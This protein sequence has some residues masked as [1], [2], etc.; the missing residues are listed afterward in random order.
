MQY[1]CFKT[2]TAKKKNPQKSTLNKISVLRHTL[3]N[4]LATFYL[5]FSFYTKLKELSQIV[6]FELMQ[7]GQIIGALRHREPQ[8]FGPPCFI[9]TERVLTIKHNI[10]FSGSHSLNVCLRSASYI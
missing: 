3:S 2:Q 6:Y 9:G 8:D 4:T 10:L 5:F 1:V 7:M